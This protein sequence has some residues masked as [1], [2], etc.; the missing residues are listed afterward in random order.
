MHV[1]SATVDSGCCKHTF[2]HK[3]TLSSWVYYSLLSAC[4]SISTTACTLLVLH[5]G[6]ILTHYVPQYVSGRMQPPRGSWLVQCGPGSLWTFRILSF[7]F[8]FQILCPQMMWTQ[9]AMVGQWL[10]ITY[11]QALKSGPY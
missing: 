2:F 7:Q 10:Y 6:Q 9:V 3:C 5:T 8:L 4:A 11:R 1:S